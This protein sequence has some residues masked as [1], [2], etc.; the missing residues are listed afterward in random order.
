MAV[1]LRSFFVVVQLTVPLAPAV[2]LDAPRHQTNCPACEDHKQVWEPKCH[3]HTILSRCRWTRLALLSALALLA[4]VGRLLLLDLLN[5]HRQRPFVKRIMAS[6]GGGGAG[7][8]ELSCD[9]AVGPV[10]D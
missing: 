6:G 9:T 2:A 5:R 3:S 7:R 10:H 4:L 1:T 8:A